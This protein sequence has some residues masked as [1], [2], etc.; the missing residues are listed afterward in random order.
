MDAFHL[1]FRGVSEVLGEA[2]EQM[3]QT[4]I[5]LLYLHNELIFFRLPPF[6]L[7]DFFG[8]ALHFIR[9]H[10]VAMRRSSSMSGI[11]PSYFTCAVW[12]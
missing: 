1:G 11:Q 10:F 12:I 7:A 8:S 9:S 2:A 6:L 3:S 4:F 5:Y